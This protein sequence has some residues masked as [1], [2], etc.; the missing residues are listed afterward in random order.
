MVPGAILSDSDNDDIIHVG[1]SVRDSIP[2]DE[3]K[4]VGIDADNKTIKKGK[5]CSKPFNTSTPVC[6]KT[7]GRKEINNENKKKRGRYIR[8]AEKDRLK[9]KSIEVAGV[10][11]SS[12]GSD[13]GSER[14]QSVPESDEPISLGVPSP[15]LE[16]I[17][18]SF[19]D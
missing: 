7:T 15:E 14:E 2:A 10:K 11:L 3:D 16:S 9:R 6:S 17:N 19:N 4:A 1:V 8:K 13:L 5:D 12:T 18:S